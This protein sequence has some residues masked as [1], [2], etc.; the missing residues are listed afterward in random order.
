[1]KLVM[2]KVLRAYITDTSRNNHYSPYT[3]N[4][5]YPSAVFLFTN[6]LYKNITHNWLLIVSNL[7]RIIFFSSSFDSHV[8]PCYTL[9]I[10]LLQEEYFNIMGINLF[11]DISQKNIIF[12]NCYYSFSFSLHKTLS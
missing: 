1:M 9:A 2:V 4:S 5:T 6:T 12:A 3:Q 8:Y 7:I 11:F 10:P